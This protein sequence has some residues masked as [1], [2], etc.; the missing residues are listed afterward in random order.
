M[1]LWF[2]DSQAEGNFLAD[3]STY[4]TNAKTNYEALIEEFGVTLCINTN[5][6]ET[7]C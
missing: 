6:I 7:D 2:K 3:F 1:N 4:A 5:L